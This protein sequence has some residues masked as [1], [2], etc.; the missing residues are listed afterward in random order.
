MPH[1]RD[2]KLLS[3]GDVVYLPCSVKAISEGETA[4]NVTLEAAERPAGEGYVPEIACNSRFVVKGLAVAFACLPN[5]RV[6][7]KVNAQEGWVRD[8]SVDRDGIR[9][10]YIE[11]QTKSGEITSRWFR[12]GEFELAD[13]PSLASNVGMPAG[14]GG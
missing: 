9:S 1:D 2:G 4:C 12:E 7:I 10:Y 11:Y 8:V 3:Q 14:H 6:R 13:T 5:Q